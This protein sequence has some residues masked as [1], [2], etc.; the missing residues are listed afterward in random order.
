[1]GRSAIGPAS[2]R[3]E[4]TVRTA[5]DSSAR[6]VDSRGIDLIVPEFTELVNN[7]KEKE[8]KE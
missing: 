8:E 3:I 7:R 4:G 2:K 5:R 6:E 1:M